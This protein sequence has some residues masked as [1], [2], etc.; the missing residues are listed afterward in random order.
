VSFTVSIPTGNPCATSYYWLIY[1]PISYRFDV[2]ADYCW[3]FGHFLCFWGP[4]WGSLG[5]TYTVHFRLIGKPIVDFLFVLIELFSLCVTA[6]ELRANTDWKS[7]LLNKK[8]IRRWDGERELSLRSFSHYYAIRPESYRIRWN[9][10]AVR[11][12][13]PFKVIQGHRVWYQ[14]KAHMRLPISH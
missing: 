8:L 13:T 6:E 3:N 12:I 7:A 10:V 14:S 5:A 1:Y 11:P 4:A 2:I 9:Y